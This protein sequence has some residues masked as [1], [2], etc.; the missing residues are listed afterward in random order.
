ML[1]YIHDLFN[2][3]NIEY[4]IY[5]GTLLGS[6]RHGGIIPWDTDVDIYIHKK[7][8]VQLDKLKPLIEKE[9]FHKLIIGD[10]V[11]RLNYSK[12]NTQHVDIFYYYDL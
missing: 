8:K 4:F 11:T 3:N 1:F 9:T 7:N 5:W 6:I 2:K 12:I 10:I